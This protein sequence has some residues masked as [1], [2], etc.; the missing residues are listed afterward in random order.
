MA[1]GIIEKHMGGISHTT[2]V[3][4]LTTTG[5]TFGSNLDLVRIGNV[6]SIYCDMNITIDS[7]NA[8]V[9]IEFADIPYGY[10]PANKLSISG[11]TYVSAEQKGFFRVRFPNNTTRAHLNLTFVGVQTVSF[12]LTYLTEDREP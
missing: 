12:V 11:C 3:T 6:V 1:S 9:Y 8:N 10:R 5:V 2:T 7:A 4:P